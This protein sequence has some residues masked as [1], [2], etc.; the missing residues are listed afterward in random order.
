M[1]LS[2]RFGTEVFIQTPVNI[3][4]VISLFAIIL[5]LNLLFS[6][7]QVYRKVFLSFFLLTLFIGVFMTQP[8]SSFIALFLAGVIIFSNNRK[9]K[10]FFTF[11]ILIVVVV[12]PFKNRFSF[13]S[14]WHNERLP[15]YFITYEIIK[16]YPIIGIGFGIDTYGTAIDLKAYEE[17]IPPEIKSITGPILADPHNVVLD[18]T[19]RLGV[20]GL[21]LSFY[22]VFVFFKMTWDVIKFGNKNVLK[23]WGRCLTAAFVAV[24]VVGQFQPIFSH[25]PEVVLCIIF[26][27][28]TV[29]WRLNDNVVK[30]NYWFFSIKSRF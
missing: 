2:A 7:R 13:E 27:M 10:F 21:I 18:I 26:S 3:I 16:T 20:V 14:I 19:V 29:V 12:T 24:L 11:A 28:V 1:N 4:G 30:D 22:I 15:Y 5:A 25:M 6:E 8:R 23:N 17:K 9:N